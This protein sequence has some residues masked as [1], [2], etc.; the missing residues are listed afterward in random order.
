MT[1]KFFQLPDPAFLVSI[2]GL[3]YLAMAVVAG[4]HVVLYKKNAPSA[5]SWLGV[6]VLSPFFGALLYWLFGVNRIR[7]LTQTHV[8]DPSSEPI[9]HSQAVLNLL[10]A[11]SDSLVQ[12]MRVGNL[13]H[14]ASYL[15]GNELDILKNGD[16]AY[17]RMLDAIARAKQSVVLSSYIFDYD[18]IGKAFVNALVAAKER[19]VEVRVLIDGLG[20]AYAIGMAKPDRMLKNQGVKTA[21]FLST[22][23]SADTRFI[24]LRNHRKILSVDGELAF[25][26]GINIREGNMLETARKHPTQDLHF[27]IRGPVIDQINTV[28]EQDWQFACEE[29]LHLPRWRAAANQASKT[30]CRIIVDGPDDNYQKLELSLLEAI[31]GAR[32][33]IRIITPYFLPDDKILAALR[34]AVL[35]GVNAELIVPSNNNLRV[36]GWAMRANQKKLIEIGINLYL[37]PEPF[38]H[39][40]LMIVDNDWS[41]IGSSNWDARSLELNFEIN[42]ECCSEQFVERC[43]EVF[44]EKQA[45]ATPLLRDV[46]V[47]F[48]ANMRNNFFR[49]FTPY[50]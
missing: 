25:L 38:D 1:D 16:E 27:E 40:K 17:P 2:A 20:I 8:N 33:A 37:S 10:E 13:I 46:P 29:S 5:V 3:V 14:R 26:G 36:V 42:M 23:F 45:T 18:S 31:N 32:E 44:K 34:L 30:I 48:L 19:G 22:L 7:R 39:S 49:L 50:L 41:L 21:R 12:R 9:D 47:S 6:I 15:A 28:F 4:V 43:L 24:N 11:P 35:R